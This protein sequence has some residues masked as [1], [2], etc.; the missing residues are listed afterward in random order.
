MSG[1]FESSFLKAFAA[2]NSLLLGAGALYFVA[3]GDERLQYFEDN[4][5]EGR[6]HMRLDM[7][8]PACT[9]RKSTE[10]SY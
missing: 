9:R 6:G 3:F 4:G 1:L 2:T 8:K 5:R 7:L 10:G